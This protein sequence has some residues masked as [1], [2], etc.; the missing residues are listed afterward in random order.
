MKNIIVAWC[1]TNEIDFENFVPLNFVGQRNL[2]LGYSNDIHILFLQGLDR[3]SDKYKKSLS[4]LGFTIQDCSKIYNEVAKKYYQFD[5]WNNSYRKN[6]LLKW[7]VVGRFLNGENVVHY[8]GD[9]VFNEDPKVIAQKLEGKTF[10]LQ[11]C[12]AFTVISNHEWF[13]QY[14]EHLGLFANDMEGYCN[15]AWEERKGWEITFKMRWA[16]SRF[17]K[18]FLHDQDLIS[19]LIHTGRMVQDS[20]E[21][22]S[23]ALWDYI[24][25]ENP[26]FI[27][28]YDDNFPYRYIRENNV[29]YFL[30]KREDAQDCF[31][32]K[33]VLFWHMQSCFNFYL[34]KYIL[35]KRLFWML[36]MGRL[37]LYLESRGLEDF[38]NKKANR[39]LNHAARLNVYKYFF[40]KSDFS[41]VMSNRTWWKKGVFY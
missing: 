1:N 27:H 8:D 37:P 12:P 26:L 24:T 31:Y 34:A 5:Q 28:M 7:V 11:G 4:D 21:D 29:D 39:F 35:R 30:C 14:E 15:K 17:S 19:H 3:L 13:N 32:K 18:I 10:V 36:P 41:G 38:I 16:G 2:K 20:V 23:L 25:F 22:I 9:I 6:T 33:R 40:E